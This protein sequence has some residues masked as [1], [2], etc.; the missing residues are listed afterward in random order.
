MT[1]NQL[2]AVAF[3]LVSVQLAFGQQQLSLAESVKDA[4]ANYPSVRVSDEQLQAAAAGITLART[5]WLPRADFY[6]Q[7]NRATSNNVFGLLFPQSTLPNIS[8]PPNPTNSL[9]S[10]WGSAVGFLVAWEPFDFGL[11]NANVGAAEAARARAEAAV[12]RTRFEVATLTA[13]A[14]MTALAAEQ[15]L[16]AAEAQLKRA[17][18]V[19]K[20][21]GAL[22]EADLRPGAELSRAQAESALAETQIVQAQNTINTARITLRQL[23]GKDIIPTAGPFQ[24]TP[25]ETLADGNLADNPYAVEQ[26]AAIE[27]VEAERRVL[28]R[29]Y[30]PRFHVLGS[31]YARGTGANPDGTRN[32]GV[33]GLGPNIHNWAVGMSVTFASLDFASIRAKKEINEHRRL[34]ESA[35]YDQLLTDLRAKVQTANEQLTAARRIAALLPKQLEAARAAEQQATARYKAGLGS[36]IE[37]ADAQRVLTQAEIDTALGTLG[38]W[39]SMLAVAA[40]GGNLTPFLNQVK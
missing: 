23:T 8:G 37:V 30:Y 18:D 26:A 31:S 7:V 11:R 13:D 20:I 28:D 12:E 6:G 1:S 25:P 15:T 10:V 5:A 24:S 4:I 19:A 39:R 36:F 29:S 3:Y 35:R 21:V 16:R 33:S 27:E 9:A 14:Y 2:A 40:A 22:T 32:G 38:V 17:S 34:A